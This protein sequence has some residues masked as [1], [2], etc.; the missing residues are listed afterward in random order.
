MLRRAKKAHKLAHKMCWTCLVGAPTLHPAKYRI[1]LWKRAESSDESFS[2]PQLRSG[3]SQNSIAQLGCTADGEPF[4][5]G[6]D[7]QCPTCLKDYQQL[8]AMQQ[9]SNGKLHQCLPASSWVQQHTPWP[10]RLLIFAGICCG[11][12]F[13]DIDITSCWVGC[14]ALAKRRL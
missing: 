10:T 2:T 3:F 14:G 9:S 12:Q 4:V 5:E 7:W 11:L 6:S 1:L 8:A 13:A